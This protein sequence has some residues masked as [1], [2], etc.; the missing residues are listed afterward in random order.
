MPDIQRAS[1]IV[2]HIMT[3]TKLHIDYCQSFGL[4]LDDVT[5]TEEHQGTDSSPGLRSISCMFYLTDCPAACT[6]YT[7]YVLDIGQSQDYLALQLA[8]APC[9]LGYF[10]VAEMLRDHKDTKREDNRYWAWIENYV[11]EDYTEAVKLG[12]GK[13]LTPVE[14]TYEGE[15]GGGLLMMSRF[16]RKVHC[17]AVPGEDR[18]AGPDLRARY[19]GEPAHSPNAPQRQ[20]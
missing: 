15:R 20:H 18:R 14:W 9:L 10:A 2:G 6:A 17:Q 16:D 8:M 5:K 12:S 3:E 13:F 1:E 19:K 4:S 11:A 7:R